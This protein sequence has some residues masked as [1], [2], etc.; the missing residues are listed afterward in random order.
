VPAS[1]TTGITVT[2]SGPTTT[3]VSSITVIQGTSTSSLS[4][5]VIGG[6]AAGATL[7]VIVAI[8]VGAI[9]YYK[10]QRQN[11]SEINLP[12]DRPVSGRVSPTSTTD[13]T[14][15]RI[16]TTIPRNEND[17]IRPGGRLRD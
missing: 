5:G 15:H 16:G 12:A 2:E 8:V 4:G 3:P 9:L 7:I 6:I 10:L 1:I 11:R 14:V 13:K 17:E